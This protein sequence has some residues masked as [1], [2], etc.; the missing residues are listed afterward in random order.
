MSLFKNILVATDFS[1][2]SKRAA[3]LAAKLAVESGGTLTLMT[4]WA[5]PVWPRPAGDAFAPE[6]SLLVDL[7]GDAERSLSEQAATLVQ[8]GAKVA[9]KA[10][11]GDSVRI[12]E[13]ATEGKFDLLICGT[14]GRRGI[15]RLVI[16]SFAEELVRTSP[17]PV[18]TVR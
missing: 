11:L 7:E 4:T 3:E 17:I 13:F 2:M 5:P 6:P 15:G 8:L 1:E 18:L 10:L 16:G 12:A 9:T 14:H